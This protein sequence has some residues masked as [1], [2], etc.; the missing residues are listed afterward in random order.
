MYY[1]LII[2]GIA[3]VTIG[4]MGLSKEK[5]NKSSEAEKVSEQ[6]GAAENGSTSNS[7]VSRK[8][9]QTIDTDG[10]KENERY[11]DGLTD[12]ERKGQAFEM[13]VRDHFN[14]K[15]YSLVEHVNDKASHEHVTERSKYPDMVFRHRSSD[16]KFAVECK[17]RSKWEINGNAPQI[18][19]AEEHNIANYLHFSE[20]RKMDVVIIIGIGGT[21]EKPDEVYAAPLHALKK[22]THARKKYLEQ[23]RLTDPN[24]YYRF[25]LSQHTVVN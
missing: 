4:I 16:T 15:D 22:F 7:L 21:A 3:L 13:F 2:L 18:E 8:N 1:I 12:A 9:N 24:G 11:D 6:S 17:Y 5:G 23:F 10:E 20:E 19:W 14:H 25:I